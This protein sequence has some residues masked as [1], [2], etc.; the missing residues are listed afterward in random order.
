MTFSDKV[1]RQ[2]EEAKK[3]G[4]A[5]QGGGDW[6]KMVEG[7]NRFRVLAEPEM[8]FEAFKVGICYTDCGYEGTAKF[9]TYV[10]DRK[11][12]KI[13]IAKLPYT[14]GTAIMGYEKDEEYKFEGFPMPY[15]IKVSAVNAG[16]KEVKYTVMAGRAN[17]VVDGIFMDDLRKKKSIAD[18]ITKMK[19]NQKE[20]HMQD[21][22]WQKNQEVKDSLRERMEEVRTTHTDEP[23]VDYPNNEDVDSIPF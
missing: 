14:V 11:D 7:D 22:T 10:L 4:Y 6:Y 20:K 2:E 18:I 8:I 15:D 16:T 13:K 9:M 12:N 17:T 3:E 23:E 1:K 5:Q 19:A 21:G